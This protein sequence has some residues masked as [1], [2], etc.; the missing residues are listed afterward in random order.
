MLSEQRARSKHQF[1]L[2][3]GSLWFLSLLFDPE[4]EGTMFIQH[5][6]NSIGLHGVT[7][8]NIVVLMFNSCETQYVE[9]GVSW[10]PEGRA[11]EHQA[12]DHDQFQRFEILRI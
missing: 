9:L 6:S 1:R 5:I 12:N 4:D 10:E 7:S 8:Q 3:N 11:F 2:L